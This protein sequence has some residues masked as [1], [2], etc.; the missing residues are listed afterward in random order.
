[1]PCLRRGQGSISQLGHGKVGTPAQ[2]HH[3]LAARHGAV[4]FNGIVHPRLTPCHRQTRGIH[5]HRALRRWLVRTRARP[6]G[7]TDECDAL[8]DHP[9]AVDRRGQ[10]AA[11]ADVAD[12]RGSDPDLRP[13]FGVQPVGQGA[14]NRGGCP[15]GDS[16]G[17]P[18]R[19]L[20]SCPWPC[21]A[22]PGSPGSGGA[23]AA[24]C[25]AG[26]SAPPAGRW[27]PG[28]SDR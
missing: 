17:P 24:S 14:L 6:R 16:A 12:P 7:G 20:R 5:A 19:S 4:I 15:P 9:L 27:P 18:V 2:Y 22:V 13:Q 21:P 3:R 28:R 26:C 1:V 25:P 8:G 11:G 10:Q 23:G